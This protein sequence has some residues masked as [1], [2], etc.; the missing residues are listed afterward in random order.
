[1]L[2]IVFFILKLILLLILAV[3]AVILAVFL[4]VLLAPVRYQGE[5]SLHERFSAEG[6]ISWL[7]HLLACSFSWGEEGI[8]TD[9]RI[10]WFHPFQEKQGAET[11][12][13]ESALEEP[14][15]E[16][17]VTVMEKGLEE[18][19]EDPDVFPGPTEFS[20][21]WKENGKE[22]AKEQERVEKQEAKTARPEAFGE[23]KK[24]REGLFGRMKGKAEQLKKRVS[25]TARRVRKN[26]L[27]LKQKKD[28]LSDLLS[29]EKNKKTFRLLVKETKRLSKK[30]F[31][32]I[33]G[34]VSFGVDDPYLMGQIL[35]VLAFFYPY[36]GQP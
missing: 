16:D 10:L 5:M 3:L 25:R 22:E 4:S 33:K 2:H 18:M 6:K 8:K 30:L 31:P 27:S 29:D 9:L 24:R 23:E 7:F 19:P 21:S 20:S 11:E 32:Q 28:S 15:E 26:I 1:M 13:G 12:A 34:S 36:Y 35:T 14:A 17:L